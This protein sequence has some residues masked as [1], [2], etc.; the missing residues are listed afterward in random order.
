M[1]SLYFLFL[2][3]S[4]S[5]GTECY[6][7]ILFRSN[8]NLIQSHVCRIESRN[9]NKNKIEKNLV[10]LMNVCVFLSDDVND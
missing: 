1:V 8:F 3:F 10:V 5:K 7:F 6:D 4:L 9:D 2:F